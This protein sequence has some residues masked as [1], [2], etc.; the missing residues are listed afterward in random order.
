VEL[1]AGEAG[2]F[3]EMF[4]CFRR[5]VDYHSDLLDG[6]WQSG[7]DRGCGFG[8][9]AAG[10]RREDEAKRIGSGVEAG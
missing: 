9:N 2:R 10:A 6:G 7:D 5:F 4:Q 3:C 1:E 8:R